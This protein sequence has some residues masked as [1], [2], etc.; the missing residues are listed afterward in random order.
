M[1]AIYDIL[2]YIIFFQTLVY[3]MVRVSCLLLLVVVG[4]VI[5]D[6]DCSELGDCDCGDVC[7]D[8]HCVEGCH[9]YDIFIAAGVKTKV[10]GRQCECGAKP[11]ADGRSIMCND[12]ESFEGNPVGSMMYSPNPRC[13]PHPHTEDETPAVKTT[14]A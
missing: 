10:Y 4:V 7:H 9:V 5:A 2:I 12:D 8:G 6:E 1:C 11:D 13:Y 3:M 14:V